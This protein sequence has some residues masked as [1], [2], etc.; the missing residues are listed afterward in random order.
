MDAP[1]S[2]ARPEIS[3]VISDPADRAG[4]FGVYL[5][6]ARSA[7]LAELRHPIRIRWASAGFSGRV[8]LGRTTLAIANSDVETLLDASLLLPRSFPPPA[9]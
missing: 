1:A 2:P 6:R 3:R 5:P 4:G 7:Y 8:I 9:P